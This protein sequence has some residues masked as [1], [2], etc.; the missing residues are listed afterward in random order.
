MA[1][2]VLDERLAL[3]TREACD[4]AGMT[5]RMVDYWV[6]RG[7]VWPSIPARGTGSQRGWSADDVNRLARVARVIRDAERAGLTVGVKAVT[8]MWDALAAGDDW[9]VLLTA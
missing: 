5:Y 3:S 4:A 6:R 1:V 8:E 9:H 7:A 2:T